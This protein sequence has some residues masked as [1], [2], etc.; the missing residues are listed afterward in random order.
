MSAIIR[1]SKW[2]RVVSAA[3]LTFLLF[4]TVLDVTLRAVWKPI[5][6]V[7][8]LVSLSGAVVIVF[9]LPLTSWEKGHVYMDLLVDH[10]SAGTQRLLYVITRVLVVLFFL[11]LGIALLVLADEFKTAGE[12]LLTLKL[13]VYPMTYVISGICF[14]Q[15]VVVFFD[16]LRTYGGNHE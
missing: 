7:Y 9:V 14:L 1:I 12:L 15:A 2:L 13:P 16:I 8:E 5:V 6:G 11:T 10:V 4:L 3:A